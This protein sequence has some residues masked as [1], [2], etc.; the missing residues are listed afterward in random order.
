[1][2]LASRERMSSNHIILARSRR[3]ATTEVGLVLRS[4]GVGLLA[5]LTD[6]VTL[7]TL[8]SICGLHPKSANLPALALGIAVQFVGNKL[9]AFRDRSKDWLRQAALFLCVE[10]L[11]FTLNA[12]AFDVL[13]THTALPYLLCRIAT[14]TLVY[15]AV[16]LPLWTFVF[17]KQELTLETEAL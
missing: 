3:G 5:T 4:S 9:V 16:C 15:F 12:I 2:R 6:W 8:V 1:M 7:A 11:G 10:T 13:V 17:Q 14:T